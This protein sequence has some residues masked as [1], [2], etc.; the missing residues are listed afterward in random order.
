M[1]SDVDLV[2]VGD[3]TLRAGND[4]VCLAWSVDGVWLRSS[5]KGA[6]SICGSRVNCYQVGVKDGPRI[7]HPSLANVDV[8]LSHLG[9]HKCMHSL[10][11]VTVN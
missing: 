4:E 6:V 9:P 7:H 5:I 1:K 3:P 2:S 10:R 8:W 11:L